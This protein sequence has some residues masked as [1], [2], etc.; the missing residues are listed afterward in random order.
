MAEGP[1]DQPTARAR[2]RP[3]L[4]SRT[5]YRELVLALPEICQNLRYTQLRA[6]PITQLLTAPVTCTVVWSCEAMEGV[7]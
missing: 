7:V 1:A 5:A 3:D 2:G 4:R 6:R